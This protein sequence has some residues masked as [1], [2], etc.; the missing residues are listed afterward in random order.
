[1][2]YGEAIELLDAVVASYN[3]HIE[4][5]VAELDN[6]EAKDNVHNHIVRVREAFEKVRNG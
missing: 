1:M 5:L 6:E 3:L 2:E 4:S